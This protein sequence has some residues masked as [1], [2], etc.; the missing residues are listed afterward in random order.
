MR[1]VIVLEQCSLDGVLQAPGGQTKIPAAAAIP[2]GR[3]STAPP[4]P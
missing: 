3:H 4:Q 2:F 1:N